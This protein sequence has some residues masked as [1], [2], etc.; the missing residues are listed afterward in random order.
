MGGPTDHD[1]IGVRQQ[2]ERHE[3]VPCRPGAHL[4]LVHPHLPLR[5]R[6]ACFDLPT[7]PRTPAPTPPRWSPRGQTRANRR[8]PSDRPCRG[9]ACSTTPLLPPSTARNPPVWSENSHRGSVAAPPFHASVVVRRTM[10]NC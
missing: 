6:D 10:S 9:E 8:R 4:V 3:A 5:L 2:A 7:G 1:Q